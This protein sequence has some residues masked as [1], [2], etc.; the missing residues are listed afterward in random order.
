MA[1][2]PLSKIRVTGLRK[3]YKVLIQELHR[4]GLMEIDK[5]PEFEKL[6][7]AVTDLGH[8]D[9]FDL[10]RIN[11]AIRYLAPY[12]PKKGKMESMLT[13]GKVILSEK[14]ARKRFDDFAPRMDEIISECEKIQDFLARSKNELVLIENENN[15]LE[16]FKSLNIAVDAKLSTSETITVLARVSKAKKESFIEGLAR[17]SS[18]ADIKIFHEE[19]TQDFF[20]L[21]YF[22]DLRSEIEGV[23]Q[24]FD[25]KLVDLE[26][27]FGED[28]PDMLPREIQKQLEKK[29]T[30]LKS[31]VV[32]KEKR[33]HQ[34]GKTWDELRIAH[35]FYSWKKD[36][37]DAQENVLQTSYVFAFEGWLPSEKLDALSH[38]AE[39]VFV[40]EVSVDK[41]KVEKGERIPSLLKNKPGFS[42]FNGMTKMFGSPAHDDVDPTPIIA[43]FFVIFFGICLSDTGYG[44]IV[45][46]AAA[47]FLLFG[48]FSKEARETLIMGLLCGISAFIGG[49]LLGGHFG[50]YAVEAPAFLT[51]LNGAGELVFRGQLLDPLKGSGTMTFLLFSFGVGYVQVLT[52]LVMRI[53]K[54]IQNKDFMYALCDGFGW[55]YTLIMLGVWGLA[56]KVGLAEHKELLQWMLLGGAGF[57]VLTLGREKKNPIMKLVFGVLGL[58]GAMDFISNILSYSRLMALGLATGIIGAAMNMTAKV[59]GDMLPSVVGIL[60]M[61]AFM[62]FGHAINFG[63]SG[64]GAYVHSMR[65]QFIEFFGIFYAGGGRVF[66]PFTRA[67]KYLLFR[68]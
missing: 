38:W 20:R 41:L 5:N 43:P 6:S 19:K 65:L 29:S 54:G 52:G 48:K 16:P 34:L 40:G 67:K 47:F 9:A 35:D 53:Y 42:S 22:K 57:L 62:L 33:L 64:L 31:Q 10:A 44:L 49:I 37:N 63:L 39:Q 36:K 50:M 23:F 32:D 24:E 8:F 27:D 2:V 17:R 58:Y 61:V 11:F 59:L 21:T 28:Y 15:S 51:T 12:A 4:R 45:T 46:L 7:S 56:D 3:H 55:F 18:L 26:N 30:E 1:K 60:V 25:V 13:G 68:S 66:K 14:E